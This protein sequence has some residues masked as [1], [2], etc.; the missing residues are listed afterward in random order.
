MSIKYNLMLNVFWKTEFLH[1]N[2]MTFIL[3]HSDVHS[4]GYVTNMEVYITL[5][6]IVQLQGK[7]KKLI[8]GL[9]QF[10]L[11]LVL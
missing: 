11:V 1:K 5:F 9:Q 7:K 2:L 8:K 10:R 3:W 6:L 4:M